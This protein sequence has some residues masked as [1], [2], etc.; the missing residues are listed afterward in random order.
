M[1]LFHEGNSSPY[2]VSQHRSV[3]FSRSFGFLHKYNWPPR[4]SWNIVESGV[5][6][7]QTNKHNDHNSLVLLHIHGY[8]ARKRRF[9]V[10]WKCTSPW[11]VF[12]VRLKKRVKVRATNKT[13]L[14]QC[15]SVH[16]TTDVVSSNLDQCEVYN[17]MW[18]SLSVTC[19]RSVVFMKATRHHI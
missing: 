8:L 7:H 12:F 5:K 19:D 6:H 2:L 15:L 1:S 18:L 16:I 17:I 3:V 4:Y 13:V 9:H 14:H 11:K 10:R